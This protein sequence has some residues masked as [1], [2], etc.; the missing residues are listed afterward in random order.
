MV[1]YTDSHGNPLPDNFIEE[2]DGFMPNQTNYDEK[3]FL[4]NLT[5]SFKLT[6]PA[7]IRITIPGF[8]ISSLSDRVKYSIVLIKEDA[9]VAQNQQTTINVIYEETVLP[10]SGQP[11]AVSP[12]VDLNYSVPALSNANEAW[13]LKFLV[14]TDL[15]INKEIEWNDIVV[16]G[17]PNA[18]YKHYA[19]AEYPSYH[20]RD[21]KINLIS[22]L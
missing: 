5:K 21:L 12:A 20:I 2:Q 3:F 14:E 17:Y 1:R 19:V 10:N 15:H 22:L 18:S 9:S 8:T 11:V 13:H 7:K 16:E 4:N 6:E